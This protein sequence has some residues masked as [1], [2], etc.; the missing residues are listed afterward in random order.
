[1]A[2]GGDSAGALYV[3]VYRITRLAPC[4]PRIGDNLRF[5]TA[6]NY[7]R[8]WKRLNPEMSGYILKPTEMIDIL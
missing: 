3:F 8:R 4:Q 5:G 2:T 1:M 6:G 7:E